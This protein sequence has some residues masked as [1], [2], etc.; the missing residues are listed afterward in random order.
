M[1]QPAEAPRPVS[2]VRQDEI[3]Q[4]YSTADSNLL[5]LV[6][7]RL[8][9]GPTWM[10]LKL[11]GS[12]GKRLVVSNN[13]V[14]SMTVT[15]LPSKARQIYQGELLCCLD[16]LR[17]CC[18]NLLLKYLGLLNAQQQCS[19]KNCF[20]LNLDL[21]LRGSNKKCHFIQKLLLFL[22]MCCVHKKGLIYCNS[23]FFI[24]KAIRFAEA[25][26]K[27]LLSRKFTCRKMS[28]QLNLLWKLLLFL[29]RGVAFTKNVN[30]IQFFAKYL[31]LI[32]F[33]S[34][35]NRPLLRTVHAK[36]TLI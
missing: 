24:K 2:L 29:L 3:L 21:P 16:T 18:F 1:W 28:I 31:N 14:F 35:V 4:F 33:Q 12:F 32:Y 23:T 17:H 25:L 6:L 36:F 34:F 26:I 5:T 20:D 11:K 27:A 30:L 8:W 15:R 19:C 10:R 9:V 13:N 7:I 22:K